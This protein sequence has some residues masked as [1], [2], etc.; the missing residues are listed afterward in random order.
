MERWWLASIATQ[1]VPAVPSA[2]SPCYRLQ[3][4]GDFMTGRCRKPFPGMGQMQNHCSEI[5]DFAT[6]RHMKATIP[7]AR[8]TTY[9]RTL[10]R[11]FWPY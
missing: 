1:D 11:F 2:G 3:N 8:T 6:D 5:N 7:F 9:L 4:A 10:K